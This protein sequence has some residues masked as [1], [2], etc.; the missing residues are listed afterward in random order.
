MERGNCS[1]V[2]YYYFC[3]PSTVTD[4]H[5]GAGGMRLWQFGPTLSQSLLARYQKWLEK[6]GREYGKNNNEA[7]KD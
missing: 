1:L 4:F 5:M 2:V 3:Y 6:S 7:S